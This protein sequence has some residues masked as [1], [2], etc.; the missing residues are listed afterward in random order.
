MSEFIKDT[1]NNKETDFLVDVVGIGLDSSRSMNGIL[2]MVVNEGVGVLNAMKPKEV[3][4]CQ[5]SSTFECSKTNLAEAE[6]RMKAARADGG[7]AMND[8]VTTMLRELINSALK[9]HKVIAIIIT[10]G[11]EN[12]SIHFTRQDLQDAK[13]RLREIAGEESIREI[14]IASDLNQANGLMFATPGLV[15]ET[16]AP[17]TRNLSSITKAFRV[18]SCPKPSSYKEEDTTPE[19]DPDAVEID[20][21]MHKPPS[22]NRM[23][24]YALPNLS[25][26]NPEKI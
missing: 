20:L 23:K 17:A 6:L 16:S 18:A 11:Y 10:D 4:F 3:V 8:G 2:E 13:Q 19:E 15:R 21:N 1:H 24:A 14:C 5:F 26:K 9:G 12:S 22:L 7:T 25:I